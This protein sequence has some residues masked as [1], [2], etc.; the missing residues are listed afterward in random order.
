MDDNDRYLTISP[1]P[2]P[3]FDDDGGGGGGGT[4]TTDGYLRAALEDIVTN[5]PPRSRYPQEALHGLWSG[6]TGVAYLLLTVSARRPDL[7][8][9]G[10]PAADWARA[11]LGPGGSRGH[12]LRLGSHGCGI[13]DEKMAYEAVRCAAAAA[14]AAAAAKEGESSS[15]PGGLRDSVRRFV[16]DCAAQVLAVDEY[17]D[18]MLYGRAGALYLLRMVRAWVGEASRELVDP[19]I[20]EISNTILNRGPRWRWH[21][22]RY[23]G[24]VH[25]DI[26]IVTQLVLT[27]PE[28]AGRLQPVLER[29]LD[30]QLPDGN[31][32]SSE[33]SGARGKGLVQ[34]CHGAPGFVLS[35]TALRPHFPELRDRI[36]A[37]IERGRECIRMQGL[38]KKEPS[39]CHGIFGNALALAPGPERERFLA[40]A[41]PESVTRMKRADPSVFERA[42][43]GR[44]YATTTSYASSAVWAWLVWRDEEPK[45]LGYNDV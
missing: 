26:G 43:Y 24:A 34:F 19:A 25:G 7:T 5:Y 40:I 37:A 21:G 11:Y 1:P 10:R 35:L 12:N 13:A 17:P 6:P 30:M 9:Q 22:R 31:W 8:L 3:A 29:L 45:M 23:L 14:A 4:S 32:P 44:S 16:A 41:T 18:E 27:S 2:T 39:L 20:A 42:D 33:E 36:D 15:S 38:L 28:L